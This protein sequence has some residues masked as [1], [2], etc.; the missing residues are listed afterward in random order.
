MRRDTYALPSPIPLCMADTLFADA[1]TTEKTC[2]ETLRLE[3]GTVIL[4]A[5]PLRPITVTRDRVLCG[6]SI[7]SRTVEWFDG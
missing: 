6:L 3:D 7:E 2:I 4:G 5:D 1:E